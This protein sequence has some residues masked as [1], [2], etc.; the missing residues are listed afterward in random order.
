MLSVLHIE[1]KSPQEGRDRGEG[2]EEWG[3]RRKMTGDS[4][5]SKGVKEGVGKIQVMDPS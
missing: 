4:G 2:M 5:W 3:E 1:A